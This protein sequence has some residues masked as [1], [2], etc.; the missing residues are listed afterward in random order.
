MIKR[1][2]EKKAKLTIKKKINAHKIKQ[3][4]NLIENHKISGDKKEGKK[5]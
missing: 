2:I 3:S 5:Y 1:K 4:K